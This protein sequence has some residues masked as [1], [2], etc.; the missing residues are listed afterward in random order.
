LVCWRWTWLALGLGCDRE[1]GLLA[2]LS[3]WCCAWLPCV[4]LPCEGLLLW[5]WEW[6]GLL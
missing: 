1:G 6:E 2:A 4:V 3:G 5:E